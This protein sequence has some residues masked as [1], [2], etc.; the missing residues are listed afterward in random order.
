MVRRL[1]QPPASEHVDAFLLGAS[2]GQLRSHFGVAFSGV[3]EAPVLDA[4]LRRT[5]WLKDHLLE[6]TMRQVQRGAWW[7]ES[8]LDR[9]IERRGPEDAARIG[10]WLVASG[11]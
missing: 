10:S 4:L 1:Q 9:D 8:E 6:N 11:A 3:S 5:H 2:H 7:S